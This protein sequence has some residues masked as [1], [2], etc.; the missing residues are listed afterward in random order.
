MLAPLLQSLDLY[1]LSLTTLYNYKQREPGKPRPPF[2][3]AQCSLDF[4]VLV[5]FRFQT[6]R[7]HS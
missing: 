3:P 6:L 5:S 7:S 1:L 4:S 2:P